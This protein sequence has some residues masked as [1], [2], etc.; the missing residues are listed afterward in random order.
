MLTGVSQSLA[1][2]DSGDDCRNPIGGGGW[3]SR[4]DS[5]G[6]EVAILTKMISWLSTRCAAGKVVGMVAGSTTSDGGR[7]KAPNAAPRPTADWVMMYG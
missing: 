4:G 2:L 5:A 7:V 6:A 3:I 1:L